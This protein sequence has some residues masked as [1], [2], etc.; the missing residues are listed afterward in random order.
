MLNRKIEAY[1]KQ[2]RKNLNSEIGIDLRK[3]RDIEVETFIGDLKHNQDYRKFNSK[4]LKK[5]KHGLGLSLLKLQ[6]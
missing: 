2:A 5:A 1:K 3:R 6:H 4:G